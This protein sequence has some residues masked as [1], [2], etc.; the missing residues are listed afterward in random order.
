M[1]QASTTRDPSIR[2]ERDEQSV[3]AAHSTAAPRPP[4]IAVTGRVWRVAGAVVARV[5]DAG[6]AG[7][8]CY[9]PPSRPAL[10]PRRAPVDHHPR[11]RGSPTWPR[12]PAPGRALARRPDSSESV[13]PQS[14]HEVLQPRRSAA[15]T[16]VAK[17]LLA[18]AA[19]ADESTIDADGRARRGAERARSR[20]QGRRHPPERRRPPQVAP[21]PQGQRR[22]R[23]RARPDRRPRRQDDRQGRRREGRQGP[24]RGRQGRQGQGRPDRRR[25]GPRRAEQDGPRR[26]RRRQGR[27]RARRRRGRPAAPAKATAT[28]AA[29]EGR[30]EE[31]GRQG[32]RRPQ[33]G[34]D[35]QGRRRRPPRPPPRRRRPPPS[36]RAR[37]ARTRRRPD[38]RSGRFDSRRRTDRRAGPA[39]ARPAGSGS[40]GRRHRV[41][42]A[43]RGLRA[44][45]PVQHRPA[46]A[47]DDGEHEHGRRACRTARSSRS[48]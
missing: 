15:K 40:G 43:G 9:H 33:E 30:R 48:P 26:G 20:R 7:D 8:L 31:A 1:T 6:P 35:G 39:P 2:L 17:A 12:R 11:T 42:L 44:G 47:A 27:G 3:A 16:Y 37:P 13:R 25:Q 14:R 38:R 5:V 21:D 18:A 46:E 29:G 34:D 45:D 19:P 36:S 24:H 41:G 32:D 23:R 22:A 28:K 10:V 4:R